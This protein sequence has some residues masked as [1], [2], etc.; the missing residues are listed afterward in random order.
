MPTIVGRWAPNTLKSRSLLVATLL[1]TSV[2]RGGETMGMAE[3]PTKLLKSKCV[4]IFSPR[5]TA[6]VKSTKV[7]HN[8]HAHTITTRTIV[9]L[10]I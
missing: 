3:R 2:L 9:S 8:Y 4:G 1:S 6:R 10:S 7:R 5:A